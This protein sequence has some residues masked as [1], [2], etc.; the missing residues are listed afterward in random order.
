MGEHVTFRQNCQLLT[1][2]CCKCDFFLQDNGSP[3]EHAIYVWDHFISQ[4]AA[5][6]VFF[7]AHSYGGLAFVE[8][9]SMPFSLPSFPEVF[10]RFSKFFVIIFFKQQFRNSLTSV[11]IQVYE[12]FFESGRSLHRPLLLS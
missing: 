3:E 5:E 12:V 11:H 2:N 7:V 6:N 4:S 8:L 10:H 9:V 1:G